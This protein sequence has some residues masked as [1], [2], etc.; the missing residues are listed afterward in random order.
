MY[1][2]KSVRGKRLGEVVVLKG[3]DGREGMGRGCVRGGGVLVFGV[4]K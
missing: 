1:G 4:L 3:W 2:A